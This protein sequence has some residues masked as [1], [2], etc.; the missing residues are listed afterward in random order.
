MAPEEGVPYYIATCPWGVEALEM[1]TG[2]VC[3]GLERPA[4][5]TS[6]EFCELSLMGD[7]SQ[8]SEDQKSQR[9]AASHD[10]AQEVSA[11]K[12][13]S[14]VSR[15]L[16]HVCYTLE[17]DL[18]AFCSYPEALQETEVKDGGLTCNLCT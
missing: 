17:E 16:G 10:Q 11:G 4:G 6:V 13:H 5:E 15:T 7:Y 2:G 3:K 1:A 12:G 14:P 18:F 9:K 8:S